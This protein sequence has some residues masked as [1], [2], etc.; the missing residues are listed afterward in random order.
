MLVS[1]PSGSKNP[2]PTP[3]GG[4]PQNRGEDGKD[5]AYTERT[6][7]LNVGEVLKKEYCSG[8]RS[9]DGSGSHYRAPYNYQFCGFGDVLKLHV[10]SFLP[11]V[12]VRTNDLVRPNVVVLGHIINISVVTKFKYVMMNRQLYGG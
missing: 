2:G 1:R 5:A 7:V 3:T 12:L 9:D 8:P 4:A 11:N 10:F 6:G